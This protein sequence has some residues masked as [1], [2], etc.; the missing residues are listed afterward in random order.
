MLKEVVDNKLF[1]L[2][3]SVLCGEVAGAGGAV[4]RAAVVLLHLLHRQETVVAKVALGDV[5]ISH[6]TVLYRKSNK[7]LLGWLDGWI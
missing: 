1:H 2:M 3:F 7:V 4:V 5:Q 6:R